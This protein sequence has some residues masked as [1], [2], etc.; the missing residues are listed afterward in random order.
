VRRGDDYIVEP[1]ATHQDVTTIMR[2]LG[3]IEEDVAKIRR[4]LHDED[5]DN[6]EEEEEGPPEDDA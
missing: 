2:L 5:E 4:W 3:N 1:L 6:G